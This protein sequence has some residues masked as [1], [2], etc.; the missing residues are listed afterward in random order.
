MRPLE[1]RELE[2]LKHDHSATQEEV[3]T[4]I[5]DSDAAP[6]LG[7]YRAGK[8]CVMISFDLVIV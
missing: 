3:Q 6:S 4:S 8:M 2:S 1:S 5:Q 7:T